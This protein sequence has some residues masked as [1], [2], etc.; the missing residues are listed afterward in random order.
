MKRTLILKLEIDWEDYDDVSDEI[1]FYDWLD[2]IQINS[3][4]TF[5]SLEKDLL[6]EQKKQTAL[7]MFR[8]FKMLIHNQSDVNW[9]KG[10][11]QTITKYE[12]ELHT[13]V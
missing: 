1:L 5:L 8:L 7:A 2:S 13:K 9:K 11:L 3:K 10:L 6:E 12:N 4:G